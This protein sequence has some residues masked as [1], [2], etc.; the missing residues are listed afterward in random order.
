MCLGILF[1]FKYF[2]FFSYNI[3]AFCKL[4][5][6][7]MHPAT[8]RLFLP[9]GISFY[10]FQ[11]FSYV[12]DVYRGE[13]KAEKHLGKY[14]AF[15]SFFP[16][17]VAG[18]IERASNLLPQIKKVHKFNYIEATYGLKLMVCGDF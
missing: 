13:I 3:V 18:P 4:I 11:T 16:Q 1:Y 10:T 6:I 7:D 5:S 14:A 17:L 8:V 9:V 2:N 15:V 12:I